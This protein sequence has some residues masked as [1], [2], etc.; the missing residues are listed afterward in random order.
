MSLSIEKTL[1]DLTEKLKKIKEQN[2][3]YQR[4]VRAKHKRMKIRLIGKGGGKHVAS[5]Y[6]KKP[7]HERSKSS[8]PSG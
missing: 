4:A 6:T 8:P 7:S 2:E 1:H 3:P 5:S